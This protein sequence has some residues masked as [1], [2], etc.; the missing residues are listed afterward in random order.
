MAMLCLFFKAEAQVKKIAIKG[1]IT[2][3][4]G[5]PIANTTIKVKDSKTITIANGE[6]LF[7]LNNV[8]LGT[9]LIISSIGYKT[10]EIHNIQTDEF[11]NVRMLSED[12]GLEEVQIVSTGYQNIPKERATGS[13]VSLNE[14]L[15]NRRVSTDII[16]RLEGIVPGLIFNRNTYNSSQGMNDISIRGTSTIY[17][18]TSPLIIVNGFPYDGD[19]NS[20]NPNDVETITVLKDAAAASIWG[21]KSG[22]GV[23]VIETKKG[24][25]NQKNTIDFNSNI[26]IGNKPNLYYSPNF[27]NSSS[28]I[29]IEEELFKR[30]YY[31]TDIAAGYIFISPVVEIL[32]SQQASDDKQRQINQLRT[33]DV[34]KQLDKYFY[35]KSVNQQYFLDFKGGGVNSDY[36][37]SFGYDKNLESLV[38]NKSNR[39]TLNSNYNFYPL[40]N[41]VISLGVNYIKTNTESN[42]PVLDFNGGGGKSNTL[43]PYAQLVDEGG[44]SQPIAHNYPIEYLKN[45]SGVYPKDWLYRPLDELNNL[46]KSNSIKNNR[47]NLGVRYKILD[48]LS[49]EAKYL[50]EDQTSIYENYSSEETYFARNLINRFTQNATTKNPIYRV[51]VG[52]I[53]SKNESYLI[54]NRGRIQLSYQNAWKGKH[55]INAISGAEI[56]E[57]IGKTYSGTLYGYSKETTTSQNVDPTVNYPTNPDG[58]SSKIPFGAGAGKSTDRYISYYGN[59]SYSFDRKYTFSASGRIDK[60]NLFGVNTNNKQIPLYSLGIMWDISKEPFFPKSEWLPET[61]IRFTYGYN[62][63]VDKNVTGTTTLRYSNGGLNSYSGLPYAS[64]ANPGNPELRWEKTRIINGGIDFNSKNKA[65][66]GT[67]DFYLKSGID[68]IGDSPLAP[69]TGLLT[70]RGNTANTK[71]KGLDIAF[72]SRNL[73]IGNFSWIT[74]IIYNYSL[75]KVAKYK[76]DNTVFNYLNSGSGSVNITPLEGKPLYSIYAYKWGGLNSK[77]QP[78]GFLNQELSTNY[79]AIFNATTIDNMQFVGTARPT[80]FGSIRNTVSYKSWSLSFNIIYKLN[81]YFRRSSISYASLYQSWAVH[82]DFEKRWKAQGDELRTN[83][84]AIMYAPIDGNQET[85]YKF[86]DVLVEKGDH[87]RL[88]DINL[89]Y[90]L[91]N[92]GLKKMPFNSIEFY[93]Y[94]NNVALLWKANKV[95]LDPDLFDS[96]NSYPNPR[97]ISFGVRANF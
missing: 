34:R 25:R 22:N 5:L 88:Q 77:G 65:I 10:S 19:L 26:T 4:K 67:I 91:K 74:N 97:T 18:K 31:N 85:F 95:G 89:S 29:D 54:S 45:R 73:E 71:G 50:Y 83:V 76:V 24:T 53:L 70:F 1:R 12:K 81:Y 43:Y 20:I 27:L 92:K 90:V 64:I 69:S 87:F 7:E 68:L 21:V 41:L 75:D 93:G 44:K 66:S 14:H 2:N 40:K 79:N 52:G 13:Y 35:Q 15:I 36:F 59:A 86:S 23:I 58:L 46:D 6:G 11:L 3:E 82:Q 48:G 62:G 51:P 30:G 60:S 38:G 17:A 56:N 47:I 72:Q 55:E 28:F 8:Q 96:Y 33:I 32:S 9:T 37:V 63:N 49:A 80:S 94:I 16:S 84:P 61:K 39:I 42:S 78:Q 57:T